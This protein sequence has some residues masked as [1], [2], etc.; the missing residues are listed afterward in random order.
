MRQQNTNR[1]AVQP[2]VS[3]PASHSGW[4]TMTSRMS[5]IFVITS[6]LF[7]A[8]THTSKK[9]IP[10]EN[11]D[12]MTVKSVFWSSLILMGR[13]QN[14]LSQIEISFLMLHWFLSQSPIAGP[15]PSPLYPWIVFLMA[16]DH[17]GW[18]YDVML[19]LWPH[20]SLCSCEHEILG[21]LWENTFKCVHLDP[22]RFWLDLDGQDQM[23]RSPLYIKDNWNHINNTPFF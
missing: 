2:G 23:S 1:L 9:S 16:G 18:W 17:C 3:G 12:E 10:L 8:Q 21:S 15:R 5:L 20:I 13:Q 6:F 4:P 22:R 11:Q 14:K 19:S 7:P